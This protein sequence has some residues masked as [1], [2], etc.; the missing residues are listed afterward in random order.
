MQFRLTDST[1]MNEKPNFLTDLTSF[2]I[3]CMETNRPMFFYT[4][5][6]FGIVGKI[7]SSS[8][9]IKQVGRALWEWIWVDLGHCFL[10]DSLM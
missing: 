8:A 7:I 5:C 1:F 10:S 2:S 9:E 3:R 6:F 4:V